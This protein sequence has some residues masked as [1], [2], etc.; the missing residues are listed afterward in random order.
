MKA[1][2]LIGTILLS[3]AAAAQ[4]VVSSLTPKETQQWMHHLIPLPHEI[5][6]RQKI[7]LHPASV[8]IT[9]RRGAG[10]VEQR[11]RLEIVELF[12]RKTGAQP[13]GKEFEIRIGVSA[14]SAQKLRSVPNNDQAYLIRPLGAS[15]LLLTALHE[16]G[17][18]YAAATLFQLIEPFLTPDRVAIPL[19]EIVDWPDRNSSSGSNG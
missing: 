2:N 4:A 19:A 6:L 12:K 11:A 8:A 16:K 7:T 3:S 5:A 17:I 18:Y 15:A 10:S 1:I 13:S 9:L 14:E